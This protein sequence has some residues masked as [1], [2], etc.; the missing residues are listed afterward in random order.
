MNIRNEAIVIRSSPVLRLVLQSKRLNELHI[1]RPHT[2]WEIMHIVRYDA[3]RRVSVC[4]T[5][6]IQH[7]FTTKKYQLSSGAKMNR[8]IMMDSTKGALIGK[9]N[10]K[11][12]RSANR[13][14]H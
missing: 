8:I 6:D 14:F 10:N 1:Y 7:V 13:N 9:Y 12:S 3:V 5:I 2:V 11:I 4:V